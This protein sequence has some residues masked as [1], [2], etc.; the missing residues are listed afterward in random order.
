MFPDHGYSQSSKHPRT[1]LK[2][3]IRNHRYPRTEH[4]VFINIDIIQIMSDDIHSQDKLKL[5]CLDHIGT[6][7]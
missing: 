3:Y 6:L 4:R 1:K 5:T 7:N 2:L